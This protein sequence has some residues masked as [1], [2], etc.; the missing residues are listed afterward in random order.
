MKKTNKAD[1]SK[2]FHGNIVMEVAG[3]FF[4][5]ELLKRRKFGKTTCV[6]I[7]TDFK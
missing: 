3:I 2:L 6:F 5:A 1:T 4:P 7:L